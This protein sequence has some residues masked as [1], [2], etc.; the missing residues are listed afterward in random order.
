MSMLTKDPEKR[1]SAKQA[2]GHAWFKQD[3]AIL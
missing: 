2:L 3:E 1:P